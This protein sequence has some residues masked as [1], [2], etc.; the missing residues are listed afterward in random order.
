[1]LFRSYID[2]NEGAKGT[3]DGQIKYSFDQMTLD[4]GRKYNGLI[5]ELRISDRALEPEEFL[6]A[7]NAPGLTIIFR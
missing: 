4:M 5:D 6:W 3:F 2:R 7:E 1:M